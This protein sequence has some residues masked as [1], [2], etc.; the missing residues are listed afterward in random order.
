[1]MNITKEQV[2]DLNA[3]V[4]IELKPDDYQGRVNEVIKNYQRSVSVPG[5]RPGKVPVG[6]IKKMYGKAVLVEELN[7]M[8]SESL[9]KYIY[10]NKLDVIGSPLPKKGDKEPVFEDGA[11]FEF[12]Y[13]LGMAPA[14]EVSVPKEEIPFYLIKVD[15]KMID[16][17]VADI[18]RRYGK[19][20]NPEISEANH[21]LYGEFAELDAEGQVKEGGH[22]TTTSLS[23]E[24]ISKTDKQKV[25]VGLRKADV[26]RFNPM[27]T[28]GN[29][30]EVAA[31][32]KVEK[33]S[34]ALHSDYNFTVNT[35]NQIDKAELNDELFDKLYGEGV[36]KTEEEFR[37]KVKESIANY[38]VRESDRKLS[39]DLKNALLATISIPLP[40]EF[41][42]RMLKAN[43]EKP[44]EEEAF[45]HEYYHLSEDLRW[46]LIQNKVASVNNIEITDE[47][48]R[49][50]A[51]QVMRQ[52]FA[53]YGYYDIEAER[54]EEMAT[55]YL[56]QEGSAEKL[57]RSI[58]E[59]KVFE[60]LKKQIKVKE[61]ELPYAE[62]IERLQEKTKHEMDHH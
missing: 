56:Q 2:D 11:S 37:G 7:K 33:D 45:Q 19:F 53:Q 17:D 38:F 30:V 24:L 28:Y 20:S 40:D 35:I 3:I 32:L 57:E 18:R 58:K 9:G 29:D 27:E 6:V 8:L 61:I 59:G 36:V 4:K 21:V 16:D 41:L 42:H 60:Q 13:E 1:M 48:I 51:R 47:E 10:D 43:A 46:S 14:F 44:M 49:D 25:F 5:F 50:L 23:L 31:M 52:E 39:K 12:L 62:Y 55:R 15:E 54:L 34:A 26:V 22:K